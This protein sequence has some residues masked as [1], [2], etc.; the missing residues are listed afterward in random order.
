MPESETQNVM[1]FTEHLEELRRRL[2]YA[3]LALLVGVGISYAFSDFLFVL[4]AQPLIKAW[5]D[6]GLGPPKIHF[7]NPIEPFFTYIKLSLVGG[8]F[9]ASPVIFYQLWQ[10][11][12]P[13]LYKQEKK[14]A[15]PF[16]TISALFFIG[17]AAFGYFIVFPYGFRFFLGY[18]RE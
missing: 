11:I 12:A 16:A 7:A 5:S 18:A 6:A 2:K 9:I 10:F 15:I 4:L 13:G 17:G 8:I 14:Y 3:L 1:S